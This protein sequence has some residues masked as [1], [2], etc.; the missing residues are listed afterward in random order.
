M[1]LVENMQNIGIKKYFLILTAFFVIT[2]FTGFSFILNSEANA[3]GGC[4]QGASC[5]TGT[6]SGAWFTCWGTC[7]QWP[8]QRNCTAPAVCCGNGGSFQCEP[9][10]GCHTDCAGAPPQPNPPVCE[11]LT[12]SGNPTSNPNLTVN[13]NIQLNWTKSGGSPSNQ[14]FSWG[15]ENSELPF[16][17]PINGDWGSY[18]EQPKNINLARDG[19][20][21]Q[22]TYKVRMDLRNADGETQCVDTIVYDN[23]P[24]ILEVKPDPL[25][26]FPAVSGR[27]GRWSGTETDSDNGRL[28]PNANN[29]SG[30]GDDHNSIK[31]GIKVHDPDGFNDVRSVNFGIGPVRDQM[32]DDPDPNTSCS[33]DRL[34]TVFM[35]QGLGAT[36]NFNNGVYS[37]WNPICNAAGTAGRFNIGNDVQIVRENNTTAWVYF[38]VTFGTQIMQGFLDVW[39]KAMDSQGVWS[40]PDGIDKYQKFGFWGVDTAFPT[41][42]QFRQAQPLNAKSVRI[43][44]DGE[45]SAGS[46]G[47]AR[48]YKGCSLGAVE[49]YGNDLLDGVCQNLRGNWSDVE[50]APTAT[51]NY[52]QYPSD[53]RGVNYRGET[54]NYIENIY[55][56]PSLTGEEDYGF[57]QW[58]TDGANNMVRINPLNAN[59]GRSWLQIIQG[60]VFANSMINLITPVDTL[61]ANNPYG[62][63]NNQLYN[64]LST[65]MFKTPNAQI[66][67]I[68]GVQNTTDVVSGGN[69]ATA[70]E[71]QAGLNT[72]FSQPTSGNLFDRLKADALTG[73]DPKSIIL[74]GPADLNNNDCIYDQNIQR[75][76]LNSGWMDRDGVYFID[77]AEDANI[78]GIESNRWKGG[79]GMHNIILLI[80]GRPGSVKNFGII[81]SLDPNLNIIIMARNA[82]IIF[83]TVGDESIPRERQKEYAYER[84]FLDVSQTYCNRPGVDC[85]DLSVAGKWNPNQWN[86]NY[87]DKDTY[88]QFDPNRPDDFGYNIIDP[89]LDVFGFFVISSN[90]VTVENE[91]ADYANALGDCIEQFGAEC[92]SWDGDFERMEMRGGIVAN[93]VE[94]KRNLVALDN[95]WI[96]SEKLIYGAQYID[97]YVKAA[98]NVREQSMG[99]R[100]WEEVGLDY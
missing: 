22:G 41:P 54:V 80:E 10:G 89:G 62:Q 26:E 84:D 51:G 100:A 2:V 87:K 1:I 28:N 3:Q 46:S 4:S 50:V 18:V 59:I 7:G 91:E 58:L 96:P 32:V 6:A 70:Y 48:I 45:E 19:S 90:K 5:N 8:N 78:L 29:P 95:S 40:G 12:V 82:N 33:S 42:G 56:N 49:E 71:F 34:E 93:R 39:A 65:V 37:S 17:D 27:F 69:N 30:V 57:M 94:F 77:L 38:R 79:T 53:V 31:F 76:I 47:I 52:I 16:K 23:P 15:L 25:N 73:S 81:P 64:G 97:A 75:G 68:F 55:T 61:P 36:L 44:W 11:S 35:N 92:E 86:R 72:I 13:P 99:F 66:P 98:K 60:E 9:D 74:C 21:T 67:Q 14:K 20:I 24:Q 83:R 85:Y 63:G 88:Y 43:W